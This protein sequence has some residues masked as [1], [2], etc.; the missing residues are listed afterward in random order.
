M[1]KKNKFTVLMTED[2]DETDASG[3]L[4]SYADM[5]TLIACFFIL[6]MAFAHFEKPTFKRVAKEISKHFKGANDV[7]ENNMESLRFKI[8]GMIEVKKIMKIEEVPEGLKVTFKSS[9]LFASGS[10]ELTE[11]AMQYLDSFIDVIK[12]KSQDFRIVVEG[13]TDNN[14]IIRGSELA[15]V[16]PSNWEL[17]A[18]RAASVV[19]RFHEKKFDANQLTIKAFGEA[20]PEVPNEDEF[21]NKNPENQARNRRIIITIKPPKSKYF[22]MGYGHVYGKDEAEKKMQEAE[23]VGEE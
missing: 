21:G 8:Q 2:E 3:W 22:K 4:I 5:M 9:H 16:M 18:M 23:G 12:E 14:P 13:H 11:E 19:R 20:R 7:I 6:M 17:S 15:K 10:A 1:S